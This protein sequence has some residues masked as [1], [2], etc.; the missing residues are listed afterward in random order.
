MKRWLFLALLIPNLLSAQV[1]LGD[2]LS[3]RENRPSRGFF[4][5]DTTYKLKHDASLPW[6]GRIK[7]PFEYRDWWMETAS[8]QGLRASHSEY[9]RLRYFYINADTFGQYTPWTPGYAG[10][11]LPDSMAI[12]LALPYIKSKKLLTHEQTHALMW[13]NREPPGHP[14]HRYGKFACGFDYVKP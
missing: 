8:C 13:F 9:T 5:V 3:T 1:W 7:P 4:Y 11:F 14:I 12:Y 10:Y 6:I 2:T